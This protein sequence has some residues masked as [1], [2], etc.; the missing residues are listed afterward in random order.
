MLRRWII[1]TLGGFATLDDAIAHI[2]QTQDEARKHQVLTEAVKKLF[3]TIGVEDILKQNP[4]GTWMYRDRP[5]SP[6][7][8]ENLR[9]EAQFLQQSRLWK[10]IGLDVKYQLNK[11]MFDESVITMDVMWGKL[12]QYLWDIVRTR[13]ERMLK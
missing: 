10:L 13:M 8:V 7:E 5:L 2:K 9:T 3:N 11:K 1:E 4:N 12:Q 6:Q